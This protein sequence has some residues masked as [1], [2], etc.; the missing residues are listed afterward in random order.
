MNGPKFN[1]RKAYEELET[2]FIDP[3]YIPLPLNDETEEYNYDAPGDFEDWPV[4]NLDNPV[5][6]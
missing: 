4:G 2:N 1:Y 6:I 5:D 3:D